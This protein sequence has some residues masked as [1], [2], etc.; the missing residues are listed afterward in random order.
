M[1]FPKITN[2]ILLKG[3]KHNLQKK[4]KKKKKK[5]II[6]INFYGIIDPDF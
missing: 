4:K 1:K 5:K 3:K 2:A 6:K